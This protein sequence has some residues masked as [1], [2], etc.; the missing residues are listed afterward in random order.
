MQGS[1]YPVFIFAAM[2]LQSPGV[3]WY[4]TYQCVFPPH[5]PIRKRPPIL[6]HQ[7]KLSSYLRPPNSFRG[8]RNP[9]PLHPSLLVLEIYVES[10][11]GHDEQNS[12]AIREGLFGAGC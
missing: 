8:F 3:S 1:Q 4:M 9:F 10:R 12:G 7:L 6:I 5:I 2:S 11:A